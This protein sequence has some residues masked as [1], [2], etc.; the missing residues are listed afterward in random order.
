MFVS[1]GITIITC[2]LQKAGVLL[3]VEEVD[4]VFGDTAK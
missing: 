1:S 4:C 3:R 2:A